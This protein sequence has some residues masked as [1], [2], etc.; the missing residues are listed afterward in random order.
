MNPMIP[1]IA[2]S[3]ALILGGTLVLLRM[4]VV[5]LGLGATASRRSLRGIS[6][7]LRVS[8]DFESQ[9]ADNFVTNFE[10]HAKSNEDD[11]KAEI[12]GVS[13]QTK[14]RYAQLQSIPP[15]VAS[16]VQIVISLGALILARMYFEAPI[17]IASLFTGPLFVNWI[18]HKR[19][20][21][22][23]KAFDLD[24]PQFLL[25][26][27]G[28]L[29]TGLNSAQ[30]LQAAAD[31]LEETSLVRQEVQLMLER[32]RLGVPEDR[33]IGSFGE[34]IFHSEIELFVQALIL[35][36]RVGGTLSDTLDRLAKQA[37]KRQQFKMTAA[38]AV[39]MHRGSIWFILALILGLN[40][41]MLKVSPELVVGVWTD[42][43]LKG[44]AQ[45]LLC[46][47][48]MGMFWMKKLTDFK[49]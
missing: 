9:G 26:V 31:N 11:D 32:V 35:S 36:K 30:A 5:N 4:G 40:L 49:V 18:I 41:Y 25:S 22:R 45:G 39:S 15:Y 21:Q 6:D 23:A 47:I 34:D 42:P 3:S 33:S 24:F 2:A 14:L 37:R 43:T 48:L 13:I 29:K 1:L 7:D 16:F 19:I 28:M 38:S 46:L 17:Q 27:V 8:D 20:H 12:R 44:F 10:R